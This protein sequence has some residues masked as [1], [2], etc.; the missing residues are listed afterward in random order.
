MTSGNVLVAE[1]DTTGA[2]LG[3]LALINRPAGNVPLARLPVNGDAVR[4][5]PV[6][7]TQEYWA[8]LDDILGDGRSSRVV[9]MNSAGRVVFTWGAGT[10]LHP[11]GLALLPNGDLLVSE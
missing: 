9:R 10:L 3:E 7:S 8:A 6:E 2:G 5:V 11:T 1:T 4:A